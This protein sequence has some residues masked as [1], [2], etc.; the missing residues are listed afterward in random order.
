MKQY[1]IEYNQK[2]DEA[3]EMNS[4]LTQKEAEL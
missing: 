4:R 3:D 2:A 1:E